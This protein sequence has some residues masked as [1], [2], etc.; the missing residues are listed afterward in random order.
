[1][2]ALYC[3]VCRK[4]IEKPVSNLNYFHIREF[5]ICEPCKDGLDARLKPAVRAHNPYSQE[6][7]ENQLI[8]TIQKGIAAKK[9]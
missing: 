6:W 1:M 7:Y 2:R 9:A 3:D 5:D 8:S 4:E